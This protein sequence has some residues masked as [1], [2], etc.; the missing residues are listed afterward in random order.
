MVRP[1]SSSSSWP[2]ATGGPI[3]NLFPLGAARPLVSALKSPVGWWFFRPGQALT[4]FRYLLVTL[5]LQSRPRVKH[6][7]KRHP[8][9]GWTVAEYAGGGTLGIYRGCY[10]HRGIARMAKRRLDAAR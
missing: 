4:L 5:P 6:V 9:E 7:V 3:C 1:S 10:P 8:D 2:P